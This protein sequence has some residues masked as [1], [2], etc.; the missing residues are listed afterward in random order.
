MYYVDILVHN[1][2]QPF[3]ETKIQKNNYLG[4]NVETMIFKGRISWIE[5]F[6]YD[7]KSGH[8]SSFLLFVLLYYYKII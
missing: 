4:L 1:T 8:I 5:L 2:T 6:Y 3:M 7:L